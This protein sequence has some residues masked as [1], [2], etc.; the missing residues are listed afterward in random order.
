MLNCLHLWRFGYVEVY[1]GLC[2]MTDAPDNT[3]IA[4][5]RPSAA[6]GCYSG[7]GLSRELGAAYLYLLPIN[8]FFA[9]LRMN[10]NIYHVSV[11]PTKL[12]LPWILAEGRG[13]VMSPI[14]YINKVASI[15]WLFLSANPRTHVLAGG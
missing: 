10:Y 11:R 9:P 7:H 5:H 12:K 13:P 8:Q 3:F 14:A 6:R 1:R 4:F 15:M 2:F